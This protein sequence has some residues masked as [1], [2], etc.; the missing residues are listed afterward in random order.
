[1]S[2][3]IKFEETFSRESVFSNFNFTTYFSIS[4]FVVFISH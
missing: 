2:Y 4:L 3:E 1:M